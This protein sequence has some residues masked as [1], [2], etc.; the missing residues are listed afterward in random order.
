MLRSALP[1]SMMRLRT[2][3]IGFYREG[4]EDF[5]KAESLV[6]MASEQRDGSLSYRCR[7]GLNY[8]NLRVF[9]VHEASSNSAAEGLVA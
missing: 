7:F 8:R 4:G 2:E 9:F 6:A 1:R 5:L 3:K